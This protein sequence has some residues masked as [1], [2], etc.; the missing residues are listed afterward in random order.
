M[1]VGGYLLVREQPIRRGR[2]GWG[3]NGLAAYDLYK[4]R[5]HNFSSGLEEGPCESHS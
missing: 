3:E 1:W 2:G 4:T 5:R